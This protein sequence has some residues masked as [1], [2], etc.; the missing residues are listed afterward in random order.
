M[1]F[2]TTSFTTEGLVAQLTRWWRLLILA[3]V[4]VGLVAASS[5]RARADS[6]CREWTQ[7]HWEI[8]SDVVRLY[9][10][11]AS[12]ER[13]DDSVFELLQREAYM[14]SCDPGKVVARVHQ[15]G[16]RMLDRNPDE[17]GAI[18]IE[19]LLADAG[20]DLTLAG[21]FEVSDLA[22]PPV[23]PLTGSRRSTPQR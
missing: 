17:Y 1:A 19:G 23:A 13:L 11:G 9:L 8:K 20:M 14:T 16:W 3:A 18:V 12:Q 5:T 7:E 6:S 2:R 15:V 22:S 4:C 10:A 21:L